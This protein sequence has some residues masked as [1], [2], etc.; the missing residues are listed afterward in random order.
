MKLN[1]PL[2]VGVPVMQS[3]AVV[4]FP[5]VRPSGSDPA[6]IDHVTEPVTPVAVMQN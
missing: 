4:E 2:P 3:V 6:E 5:N 1:A